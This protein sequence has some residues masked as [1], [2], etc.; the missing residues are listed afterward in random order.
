MSATSLFLLPLRR[1][2]VWLCLGA[3][4]GLGSATDG[5]QGSWASRRAAASNINYIYVV[6]LTHLDI[7]FNAP[8]ATLAAR[9]KVNLDNVIRYASTVPE[10]RWTVEE[11]WM[12]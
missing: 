4:L 10:F 6:P 9:Y 7:G 8:P 1:R 12:L 2:A 5:R 3:A 11:I